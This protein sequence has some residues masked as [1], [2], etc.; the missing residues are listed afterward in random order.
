MGISRYIPSLCPTYVG[1]IKYRVSKSIGGKNKQY[2]VATKEEAQVVNM[3]LNFKQMDAE[4]KGSVLGRRYIRKTGARLSSTEILGISMRYGIEIKRRTR[5]IKKG[6]GVSICIKPVFAV[7]SS[8]KGIFFAK[9]FSINDLGFEKAFKEAVR[10]F[11]K[12]KELP[13]A[14]VRNLSGIKPPDI[15]LWFLIHP[16]LEKRRKIKVP[17]E[18]LPIDLFL[19]YGTGGVKIY[20]NNPQLLG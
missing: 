16:D 4:R 11:C 7:S 8:Y 1:K 17:L 20:M 3:G 2:Y 15:N 5:I 14:A 13:R 12:K 19:M 6:I 18:K 9:Q 10:F